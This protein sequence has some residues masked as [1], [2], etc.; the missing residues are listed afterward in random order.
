M[1]IEYKKTGREQF[2]IITEGESKCV[3]VVNFGG[4]GG[5]RGIDKNYYDGEIERAQNSENS[6]K[7][8][9]DEKFKSVLKQLKSNY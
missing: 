5:Y 8:E 3:I 9:F 6:T 4:K 7:E 1:K 2:K